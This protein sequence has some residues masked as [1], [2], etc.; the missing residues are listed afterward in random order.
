MAF[1]PLYKLP[2]LFPGSLFILEV[3]FINMKTPDSKEGE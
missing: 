3:R 2:I 1:L